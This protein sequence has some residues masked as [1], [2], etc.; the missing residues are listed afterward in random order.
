MA[1]NDNQAALVAA[2]QGQAPRPRTQLTLVK[3]GGGAPSAETDAVMRMTR[4]E[5]AA[6]RKEKAAERDR[7]QIAEAG[8]LILYTGETTAANALGSF[9]HGA[10]GDKIAP[11]GVDGRMVVG[12]LLLGYGAYNVAQGGDLGGHLIAFGSGFVQSIVSSGARNL[13]QRWVTP[14]ASQPAAG[15][16]AQP[17]LLPPPE[18]AE[19]DFARAGARPAQRGVFLTPED[20]PRGKQ[21]VFLTPDDEEED[22]EDDMEDDEAPRRNMHGR[23]GGR[24]QPGRGGQGRGQGGQ[25]GGPRR[26]R[27][28]RFRDARPR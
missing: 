20:R 7:D 16:A 13:G 17:G 19:G 8:Q 15:A 4:K 27:P 11:L 25:G 26:Q 12:T 21:R 9:A 14:A 5:K 18:L 23:G 1:R 3:G 22:I 10:L 24:P 28:N 2:G 6:E